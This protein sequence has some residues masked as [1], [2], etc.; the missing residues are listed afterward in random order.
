M[1]LQGLGEA[2]AGGDRRAQPV[3]ESRKGLAGVLAERLE[4]RLKRQPGAD[5]KRK[6]A[7][8]NGNVVRSRQLS[9]APLTAGQ[10]PGCRELRLDR[11]MSQIFDAPHHLL[12][13]GR[14]DF[15]DDDLSRMGDGT[16]TK[17]RH[18]TA[19]GYIDDIIETVSTHTMSPDVLN[20]RP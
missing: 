12:A 15:A 2:F 14:V 8:K 17:L 19:C 16:I 9:A 20:I 11:Q 1:M 5:Q 7:Q 10:N 6:L 18:G 4:C 13:R 3:G